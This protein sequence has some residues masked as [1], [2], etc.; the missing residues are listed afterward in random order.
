[1]RARRGDGDPWPDLDRALT[2]ARGHRE[3]QYLAPMATAR[4]EAAWLAGRS[5]TVDAETRETL[6]VAVRQGAAW[7]VGELAWLRRLAG[8]REPVDGVVEPYASQLAGGDAA[9]TAK[10]WTGLGCPY[11]AALALAE[12]PDELDLRRALAEL[13]RLDAR[14]AATIVARRLRERGIR[15]VPRGPQP[16]TKNNP[17]ELTRRELEVLALVRQGLSNAEIATR[18]FLSKKTVNHHVSAILRKL[19]VTRRGQAA[20]E[21]ARLGLGAD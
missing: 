8:V 3:L 19:G 10:R 14:S 17:A 1:V 18:L 12:S 13:Q 6:D 15:G 4:A 16:R 20:A 21:A 5:E 7:V 9:A 11:D 2:L